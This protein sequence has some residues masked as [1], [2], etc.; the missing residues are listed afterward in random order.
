MAALDSTSELSTLLETWRREDQDNVSPVKTLERIAELVERENEAYHKLDPDPFDDRHPGRADPDCALGHLL[1]TLFRNDEFMDKLVNSYIMSTVEKFDLNCTAARVLLNA[2]PGL[3]SAAVFQD[4]EAMLSR[5]CKWAREASEPLRSYATGLLAFAMES[6]DIA[7]VFR[8]E[9]STL[10]PCML[11]RLHILKDLSDLTQPAV[12]DLSN[13]IILKAKTN[14]NKN[15]SGNSVN[16][17]IKRVNLA[18]PG[19]SCTVPQNGEISGLCNGEVE[20]VNS[21][22]VK[23][24]SCLQTKHPSPVKTSKGFRSNGNAICSAKGGYHI[25]PMSFSLSPLTLGMQQR[26]ILQYLTPL[27]EYQE[28]LPTVFESKALDLVMHYIT[29][30]GQVDLQLVFEALK[31]LA[32]LLCHKKFATE[33]VTHNGVQR[34]LEV[35]RP[36]VAATGCSM[37]LYYLA[38]NEDAMERV[39]LLPNP[40]LSDMV[41]YALW[42]LECS[43]DSGRCHATLFFSLTCSFR[44]VLELF[45]SNDGLRKLVN[46]LSTLSILRPDEAE[47]LSDDEVFG[48]RQT[49]KH[50]CMALRRYFDAHLHI[51]ADA[52][53]RSIARNEG[54]TPPVPVP[55][56]KAA[57]LSHGSVMENCQLM[58]EYAPTT[59]R[60]EPVEMMN[61]LQGYTLLLQLISLSSDWGMTSNRADAIRLA[62]DVTRLVLE[63]LF[64]LTVGPRAQMA[65]CEEVQLPSREQQKGMRLLLRCA[66]GS[67][68]NDSEVQKAALHVICNCVCGPR[69]RISGAVAK[70]QSKSRPA[71]KS[72]DDVLSKMWGCVRASNG[73]KVLLSLLMVKTPLVDA[74]CIRALACKALCGLSRSDKI[75]QVIGKLQLFNSGQLQI[76]MREPVI[77]DNAS[78]HAL[79]CKYAAELLERVTGKSLATSSA[80]PSLS[81]I[82]KADVVAQTHISYPA[83]ELLQLVHSH[84]TTQGLHETAE[85]LRR[86]ANL[87]GPKPESNLLSTPTN[88][89]VRFNLTLSLSPAFSAVSTPGTPPLT[90]Y[91]FNDP[92]TPIGKRL[93]PHD[94][95]RP[96]RPP[97]PPTLDM[98][99]T[100]YLREQHAQCNNPVSAGPPFSL[101]RPHKCPEPKYRYYAPSN[102]TTRLKQRE[103]IPRHGGFNG[104][105]LNR[106]FVYGRFKPLR[107][108]RDTEENS[109]FT[110]ACFAPDGK[111]VLLG[112]QI[113]EL[114]EYNLI[115]GQEEATYLCSADR[116][117]SM[118]QCSKDRELLLTSS[119]SA[120]PPCAL[121]SFGDVFEIKHPFGEDT[122]VKFSN[123][124]EDR[125]IGTHDATAH[126]YD[127]ATGQ[128]ILTLH[129]SNNTNNYSK[130]LASFNP[131]DDLVLNDGVL[132]DVKGKRVIHKFDKF[133]NFVSGVFHPS[134]LE[135]I[136]NSEIWD[137][138]SFHL[139]DTCPSLD[140]CHV[141][142]NNIGDVMYGVKHISDPLE[143]P[144][145]S[146]LLGPYETSF[147]TFDATDYQP[148]ATIDVK[149]TIFD[150]CTDITDSFVAVIENQ[151]ST[152]ESVCRVYEV[153]RMRRADDEDEQES[154]EGGEEDDDVDDDDDENDDD[155]DEEDDDDDEI[156]ITISG[157]DSDDDSDIANF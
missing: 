92:G 93:L 127:T 18:E 112:T 44:A 126:I 1:K 123:L 113:G 97:S 24:K 56:Y 151:A 150:L 50:T 76:L 138:R 102:M 145:A 83:K 128:R 32:S 74:D 41:R 143:I 12:M 27:G 26:I 22:S 47:L 130:N 31:Y 10:V 90:R 46:Q 110:C 79:F 134:G 96:V 135:I 42:L 94:L 124:S 86:E 8:E 133:N 140:Q 154:D 78:D 109:F 62:A 104:V 141:I 3:E 14:R 100:R 65:L 20:E 87:P 98:I 81:R 38:Y 125:I 39:S 67:L 118:C 64:V 54:G 30:K 6:Q 89:K 82:N 142:F 152:D 75:R 99:V 13:R 103:V 95:P 121:W 9:N 131:T 101:L 51:R 48:S 149:K 59:L 108:I 57:S 2:M 15:E 21:Y 137:L 63:M 107:A 117:I 49:A 155:D 129:D 29:L 23:G 106:R 146:R 60:W 116:A 53:R 68:L 34:L 122:W 114:K 58:L 80:V 70:F 66:E 120:F 5:L 91:R 16:N 136:I 72:S 115:T 61:R 28:L 119:S 105:R 85:V 77:E 35:P 4:M 156:E 55:A 73:I 147:R 19:P 148:I 139:L 132:W 11:R 36:S 40:V 43:H 33:F 7:A 153:G 111:S 88:R 25:V 37:C 144:L 157:D 52:L 84:L 45:D 17:K 69:V 71:F